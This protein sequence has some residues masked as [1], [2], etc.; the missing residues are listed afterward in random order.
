MDAHYP[1][2]AYANAPTKA[3]FTPDSIAEDTINLDMSFAAFMGPR[4]V[5]MADN[6]TSWPCDTEFDCGDNGIAWADAMRK[7]G[8]TLVRYSNKWNDRDAWD[9]TN[10][11]D[12]EAFDDAM[13]FLA[14][15]TRRLWT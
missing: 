5:H 4:L 9:A 12:T 1:T 7:H 14:M 3:M 13:L 6:N 10:P 15:H 2:M 8:K 11:A